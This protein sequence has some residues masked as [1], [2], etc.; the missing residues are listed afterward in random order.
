M[1]AIVKPVLLTEAVTMAVEK[2]EPGDVVERTGITFTLKQL[3]GKEILKV[4]GTL[5]LLLPVLLP[6]C[7]INPP[8]SMVY[9]LVAIDGTKF[10]VSASYLLPPLSQKSASSVL[11]PSLT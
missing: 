9:P 8:G 3:N 2:S 4:T 6:H 11:A 1:F 7:K 5:A 10:L